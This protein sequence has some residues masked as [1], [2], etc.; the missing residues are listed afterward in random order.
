VP[1]GKQEAALRR[2]LD[3]RGI[4]YRSQ[5]RVKFARYSKAP[6][7]I[8]FLLRCDGRPKWIALDIGSSDETPAQRKQITGEFQREGYRYIR[9]TEEDCAVAVTFI[10]RLRRQWN[11]LKRSAVDARARKLVQSAIGSHDISNKRRQRA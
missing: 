10:D 11:P 3:L 5:Y 8:D 4:W 1:T 6:C 9:A 2:A 7:A